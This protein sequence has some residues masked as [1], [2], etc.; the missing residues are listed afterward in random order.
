MA[1]L[2]VE[3]EHERVLA[4]PVLGTKRRAVFE[5]ARGR[6]AD[7]AGEACDT[8]RASDVT[9]DEI[10]ALAPTAIVL[11]G[12][13]TDWADYDLSAWAGLLRVIRT[14]SV[15]T[16][17]ICAGHQLI[18]YAH[19]AAWG[20]LGPLEAGEADPDPRFVPGQRKQRGFLPV[21]VD[22][23]SPLF[24]GLESSETVFQSHYWQLLETPAG[25]ATRASSAWSPIQAIEWLDRPVFGVQFHAERFDA[26][27]PAGARVLRNF[28][29]VARSR[30]LPS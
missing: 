27:H 6:L 17:G 11:S 30:R 15:P 26:T 22:A 3:L 5:A 21:E 2:Y 12:C 23:S 20:P 9:P 28:F 18:G 4:D 8:V 25:F 13:S 7:A 16:L 10:A 1:V 19:G 24:E 29:A 14:G